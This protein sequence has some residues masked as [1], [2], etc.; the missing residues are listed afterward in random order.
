MDVHLHHS[1]DMGASYGLVNH[2]RLNINGPEIL[3]C[4]H[5]TLGELSIVSVS[6]DVRNLCLCMARPAKDI[7]VQTR[8]KPQPPCVLEV[9]KLDFLDGCRVEEL[10][11][12][13][14]MLEEHF[15]ELNPNLRGKISMDTPLA[16]TYSGTGTNF[17]SRLSCLF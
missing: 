12:Y 7:T 4:T 14:C 1:V 15:F 11:V 3:F 8:N 17:T 16:G 13:A 10:L 5:E 9:V 2:P 6:L